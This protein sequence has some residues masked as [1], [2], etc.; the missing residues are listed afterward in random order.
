MGGVLRFGVVFGVRTERMGLVWQ[1]EILESVVGLFFMP[2]GTDLDCVGELF[3][4]CSV[5]VGEVVVILLFVQG[6]RLLARSS[7]GRNS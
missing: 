2:F 5:E 7:G 3:E 4:F 1:V 6:V